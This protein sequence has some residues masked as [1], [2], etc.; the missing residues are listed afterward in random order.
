M[1]T[2]NHL[3]LA[4]VLLLCLLISGLANGQ[5]YQFKPDWKVGETKTLIKHQ[6]YKKFEQ[7]ELVQEDE[8]TMENPQVIEVLKSN[9][10][11]L[12]VA[13]NTDVDEFEEYISL[14]ERMNPEVDFPRKIQVIYKISKGGF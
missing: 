4:T 3:T 7:G 14:L 11:Y 2:N 8:Q 9:P 1:K 6:V 10:D 12:E 5:N 13:M